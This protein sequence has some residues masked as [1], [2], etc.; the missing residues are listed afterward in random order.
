MWFESAWTLSAP[1]PFLT[2]E[3][4]IDLSGNTLGK[5]MVDARTLRGLLP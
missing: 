3:I 4:A 2:E 5:T 1:G